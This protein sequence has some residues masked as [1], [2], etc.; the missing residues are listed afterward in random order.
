MGLS[1]VYQHQSMQR[2]CAP[3]LYSFICSFNLGMHSID[4][5]LHMYVHDVHFMQIFQV[6]DNNGP[7]LLW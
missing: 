2:L 5:M 4:T 6:N 7:I 3:K 1:L